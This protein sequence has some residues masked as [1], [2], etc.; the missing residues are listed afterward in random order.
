[1]E[2]IKRLGAHKSRQTPG[3][4]RVT[5]EFRKEPDIEKLVQALILI[6]E[7]TA[8]EEQSLKRQKKDI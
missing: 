1:M 5:P 3:Y 8:N 4:V 2:K 6:A 7:K